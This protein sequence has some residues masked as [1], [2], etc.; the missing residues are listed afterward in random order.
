MVPF[1]VSEFQMNLLLGG[2]RHELNIR[3]YITDPLIPE[4]K[5]KKKERF[6]KRWARLQTAAVLWEKERNCNQ[7]H[8]S[9]SKMWVKMGTVASGP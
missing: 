4:E 3:N 1:K 6:S 7:P 9:F 8:Q 5:K 2:F